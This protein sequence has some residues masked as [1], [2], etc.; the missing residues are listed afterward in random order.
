MAT[1]SA[2]APYLANHPA[3][4]L[5]TEPVLATLQEYQATAPVLATLP[6]R[7]ETQATELV[8]AIPRAS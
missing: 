5:A 8:L 2:M 7:E 6:D 3:M 4:E 1:E